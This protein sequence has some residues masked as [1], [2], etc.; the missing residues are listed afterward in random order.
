[1][2]KLGIQKNDQTIHKAKQDFTR[3]VMDIYYSF[4]NMKFDRNSDFFIDLFITAINKI[5]L[6]STTKE[7]EKRDEKEM[8]HHYLE[9]DFPKFINEITRSKEG[10]DIDLK[11]KNESCTYSPAIDV[12]LVVESDNEDY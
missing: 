3:E 6:K 8:L 12:T 10:Q 1:M 4:K 9:T 2:E 7:V 11:F 5:N